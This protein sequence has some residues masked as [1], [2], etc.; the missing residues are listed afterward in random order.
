MINLP[1]ALPPACCP[2]P[3]GPPP[4]LLLASEPES[5]GRARAYVREVLARDEHPVAADCVDAVVL[6]VSELVT[7]AYR[8]GTEPGDSILV[9]VST[10]PDRVRVEVHDP[11]RRRP[12]PREA[13]GESIRGRGLHIVGALAERWGVD[14]RPFGKK[15]WA[16]VTR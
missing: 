14:D 9:V 8:Y 15:V 11:R 16:E 10:T 5:V 6:I 7:N 3:D 1:Q 2:P 13:T 12:R 4:T